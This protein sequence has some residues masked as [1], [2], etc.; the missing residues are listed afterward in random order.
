MNPTTNPALRLLT[1]L[2]RAKAIPEG[3]CTIKE[4]WCSVFDLPKTDLPGLYQALVAT[5]DLVNKVEA[6]VRQ[7]PTL[8]TQVYLENTP[9]IKAMLATS[10]LDASCQTIQIR[11]TADL[12]KDLVYCGQVLGKTDP[13][14]EVSAE[15]FQWIQQE[16]SDLFDGVV[17]SGLPS[18]L[19]DPLL[20]LLEAMRR[21]VAAYRI[22]GA[23][24]LREALATGLGEII[25]LYAEAA[26]DME[27][28]KEPV[29]VRTKS[30][31][32]RVD[33]IV[34][35]ALKYKPL[36]ELVWPYLPNLLGG[37]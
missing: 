18:E 6:R 15:D 1:I 29:V 20:D 3:S 13:E 32:A 16:V 5:Q 30:F 22:R 19:R 23:A 25:R 7:Q 36:M 37:S 11:L 28:Q 26:G 33:T 2:R 4:M 24:A 34:G 8:D 21:A 27:V 35:K 17:A 10:N 9:T 31:L 14:E 12:L